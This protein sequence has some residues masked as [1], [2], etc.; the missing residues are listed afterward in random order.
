VTD[1]RRNSDQVARFSLS[2]R[3]VAGCVLVAAAIITFMAGSLTHWFGSA[4]PDGRADA[5]AF[6]CEVAVRHDLAAPATAQFLHAEVRKVMMS[7]DDHVGLGFDAARVASMWSV[8]GDV[9]S[10]TRSQTLAS[11]GFACRAA[12]STTGRYGHRSPMTRTWQSN[13]R[14]H[15]NDADAG[16]SRRVDVSLLCVQRSACSQPVRR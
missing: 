5:A 11:T 8:T 10:R 7:E 15:R 3:I 1:H 16:E 2:H 13:A 9:E 6:A 12:C 14:F 4:K